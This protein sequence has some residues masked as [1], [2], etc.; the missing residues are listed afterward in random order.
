MM[1][2][3][4]IMKNGGMNGQEIWDKTGEVMIMIIAG[5]KRWKAIDS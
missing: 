2:A 5:P 1:N 3:M 4:K